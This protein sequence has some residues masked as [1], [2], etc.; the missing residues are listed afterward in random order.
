M[1][2]L[3]KKLGQ[4]ANAAIA[5]HKGDETKHDTGGS[6]PAGIEGGIAQLVECKFAEIAAGKTNAGK[7]YFYAAGIVL[8]PESHE[9]IPVAGR[10][11]S[12]MEVMFDTPERSRK[13]VD[14]HFAWVLNQFRLLGYDTDQLT[15]ADSF[16][17]AAAALKELKPTFRFRTWKGAKA[18]EGKYKDQ[19]PRVNE[20]WGEA[21][22]YAVDPDAATAGTEDNAGDADAGD[23]GGG[24]ADADASGSDDS[25]GGDDTATAEDAGDEQDL[26]ALAAEA[27]NDQEAGVKLV[28]IA[29]ELGIPKKKAEGTETW[30]QLVE[31]IRE[32]QGETAGGDGDGD[33]DDGPKI[34]AKGDVFKYQQVDG[35]GKPLANPKNPKQ[36]LKPIEVEVVTVDEKKETVTVRNIDTGKALTGADPKKALAIPFAK[37]IPVG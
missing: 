32:K 1:G 27:M 18:T 15:D 9:G 6:L 34:P 12:I 20:V 30:E 35:K 3:A 17:T 2:L 10:R 14:D 11:T 23:T 5:K 4:K 16:E 24:D 33:S 26:D 31:M 25:D 22:D 13:T 7:P 19:E 37:L 21:V 28:N 8:A 36:S 29:V